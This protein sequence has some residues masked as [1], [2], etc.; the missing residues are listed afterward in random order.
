MSCTAG[1][2]VPTVTEQGRFERKCA[3]LPAQRLAGWSGAGWGS[4]RDLQSPGGSTV[5]VVG[6]ALSLINLDTSM[7]KYSLNRNVL[8]MKWSYTADAVN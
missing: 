5:V 4:R 8:N 1:K 3:N 6:G 2:K 7:E